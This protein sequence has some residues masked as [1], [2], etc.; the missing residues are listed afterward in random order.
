MTKIE[1]MPAVTLQ[2]LIE[3]RVNSLDFS[4]GTRYTEIRTDEELCESVQT[5]LETRVGTVEV[6]I[7]VGQ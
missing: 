5:F 1:E 2:G 4:L 7:G 3:L 6:V